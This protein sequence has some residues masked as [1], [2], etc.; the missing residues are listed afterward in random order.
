MSN[1]WQDLRFALRGMW[2]QPGFTLVAVITLALGIGSNTAIFSVINALILK[3]PQI[4]DAERV[5]VLWG[6]PKDKREKAPASYLDLQ[7]WRAHTQSFEAIAAYKPNGFTLTTDYQAERIQGMRVTANFLSLLKVAPLIGRDFQVEEE[8]PGSKNVVIISYQVWQER[9]NGDVGA[10]GRELTVDGKPFTIIGVLPQDFEFPLTPRS[11]ELLT[12][13]AAEGGNLAERGAHVFLTVARLKDSVTVAQAQADLTNIAAN[14]E[15]AYPQYWRNTTTYLVPADEQIVGSEMRQG[16]WVLLGAVVFLLLI[17]CTNVSNLLLV[18][19]TVR[20][21]ELALRVA[22]GAGTWRI[23]RQWLTE[24]LLLA[25]LSA[26]AGVWLAA[27]GL[28]AIK[29]YGAGQLPRLN[30]VEIDGPVL[31]FTVGVSILAAPLFS[32]LPVLKA[33]RPDINE[34]LKAG[35][36]TATSSGSS[37]WWRDSLVVA[38]VALGLVLLIGAG[39]MMRSFNSLIN[40]PPGFDPNHVLTGRITLSGAAYDD[41]EGRRRYV[42][43]TLE[44]L[45]ALPGVESAAFVAPMPFSGAEIAGDFKIEGHPTEPGREP[46]ASVRNVTSAYFQTIRIPLLKGRYFNESDQRNGVGVAIINETFAQRYLI[47]EDP[48]GKRINELGVNQN[49]G[50]PKQYE[51]VGVVGDVHHNSLVR[52]ATPELYLSHQQNSWN[53]GN[54]LIRTRD[55]PGAL[56]RSFVDAVRSADMKVPITRVRPLTEAISETVSESRFYTLLFGLFGVTGLLLT[57]TGIYSVISYTVTHN[58]R[59]IGIRM[60]LGAK[61]RD[62]LKL[63]VGKGLVLTLTGVG[64]GLLGALGLTRVMQTLLFGISATDWVT[65]AGVATLLTFVGVLAAAIPARRATKVDPLI[66]LR[67]E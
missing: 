66:A 29:Y 45:K 54:F 19:A 64:L 52:K 39:L 15:Q 7:D 5:V 1:L 36:K 22:L 67:Y 9:M 44:R 4:A 27:I 30:E 42:S 32:L 31:I 21:R 17:A 59:E 35:A 26:G 8:K 46:S 25:L 55:D 60:A 28:K 20:Q 51:I 24:S 16:L 10:L 49:P 37:Q 18:R 56:T 34:I 61:G 11:A 6:T 63:I 13:I 48:I 41:P 47:D 23:V 14:L 40:V 65:F 57:V 50:D 43:Q 53:W 58:T 38:E 33:S 12:T 3:S 2:K 62:V